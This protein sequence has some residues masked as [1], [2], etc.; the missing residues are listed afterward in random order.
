MTLP[1][2]ASHAHSLVNIRMSGKE[3][4]EQVGRTCAFRASLTPGRRPAMDIGVSTAFGCTMQRDVSI[5]SWK[6]PGVSRRRVPSLS[7]FRVA[8]AMRIP[9]MWGACSRI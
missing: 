4:I 1:V 8:S 9:C 5:G 3:A 2:S 6:W 7:G